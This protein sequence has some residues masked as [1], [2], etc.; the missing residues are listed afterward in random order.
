MAGRLVIPVR[1][2][3]R[4]GRRVAYLGKVAMDQLGAVFRHDISAAGVHFPSAPLID[5]APTARCLVLVTPDGQ[6][7]M[8]TYLGACVSFGEED[9]DE[10]LVATRRSP[11]SRATC[12]IRRRRRRRSVAPRR[13]R[14][15]RAGR[16]RCRCR[17]R[18]ASIAIVR[19]SATLWRTTSTSCSPMRRRSLA[20]RGEHV[21]SGGRGGAA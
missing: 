9:V 2:R 15:P 6:R 14:T 17:I 7:T 21:R 18:S 10:E 12:S 1:W 13:R 4:W 11:I 16:W 20:L 5:G 3:R 19:H 8:N